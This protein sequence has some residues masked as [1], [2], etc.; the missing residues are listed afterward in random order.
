MLGQINIKFIYG[1]KCIEA[2]IECHQNVHLPS[3]VTL[4]TN[5]L[6]LGS[7]EISSGLDLSRFSF[8]IEYCATGLH[9]CIVI[10]LSFFFNVSIA[11][12]RHR[13]VLL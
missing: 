3:E 2:G 13:F 12:T 9:N 5:M 10:L 7:Q 11:K 1:M 4:L 8:S 6:K